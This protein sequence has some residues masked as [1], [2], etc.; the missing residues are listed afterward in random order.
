MAYLAPIHKP[1]SIRHAVK[2]NLLDPDE[3]CLVVA[4]ANKIEIWAF[5]GQGL[6][7]CFSD[8]F[9]GRVSMLAKIRPIGSTTDHL[10]IGTLRFSYFTVA[11][12]SELKKLETVN[13]FE[14]LS[15]SHMRESQSRDGCLVDPTGQYVMLELFEGV[16]NL[17]KVTKPRKGRGDDY[18]DKAEQIRLSE[19]KVRASTFLFTE[20]KQPKIALLYSEGKDGNVRLVTYQIVDD[21]GHYSSFNPKKDRENELDGLDFSCSHLIPVP[22]GDRG[23]KRYMVRNSAVPKALLGGII[24]VS[25]SNMTY[26]DDESNAVIKYNLE[27]PS[28]FVAW[29]KLDG[30]NYLLADEYARLFALTILVDGPEVVGMKIRKLGKTTK[31]SLMVLLSEGLVFIASHEGDSQ[32]VKVDL[33]SEHE[34]IVL[35]QTFPNIGPILDFAVMDIGGLEGEN[36]LNDYSSGQ[37]Q[38]VTGSGANDCG[39]VR[40]VRSGVGLEDEG[41]LEN[42]QGVTGIFSLK[43][44]QESRIMDILMI[45]MPVETRVFEFSSEGSIEEAHYFK[46]FNLEETTLLAMNTINGQELQVTPSSVILAGEASKRL[47]SAEW[48]PPEGQQITA[49]SGN[50]ENLLLALNGTILVSLDIRYELHEVATREISS[51]DQVACIFV[52]DQCLGIGVVGFWRSGSISILDLHNLN[53]IQSEGLQKNN[54]ASIP[55]SVALVQVLPANISGPTLF[56]AMEDGIVLT[57][58]VDPSTFRLSGKKSIALGTQQVQFFILPQKNGLSNIFA[59]SEHPSL[60]YGSEGRIIYSAVTADNVISVCS[61]DNKVYADTIIVA[62]EEEVKISR[63]DTQRRTHIRTLPMGVTVRRIA[64]SPKERVLG[65]GC[66]KRELV[67]NQETVSCSFVIAEDVLFGQV[68]REF[69]LDKSEEVIECVIQSELHTSHTNSLAERFIVGT[70]FLENNESNER[71]RILIF[72]IDQSRS[73]YLITSLNLKCAC[74]RVAILNGHIVAALIKTVVIYSYHETTTNSAYLT[75]ICA[76]R[77]STCPID[78]AI[79]DNIIAVADLQKSLVLLEYQPAKKEGNPDTLVEIARH[80]HSYWATAVSHL[81]DSSYLES[82]QEGNLIILARNMEGVTLED[83]RRLELTGEFHL[84][85]MVNRMQKIQV[86]PTFNAVIIPRAFLA[87]TEGSIYLLSTIAP[88]AQD[89][90]I[91]LQSSIAANIKTLGNI[92]FNSY[93]SF[94]NMDR[95]ASE[96]YRFIDGELI[97]RFLDQ[98]ENLQNEIC[99]GLGPHV[100]DIRGLVEELKRLH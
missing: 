4:K 80:Y 99:K 97:E 69:L 53:L 89:L 47:K 59:T 75:K 58:K 18:L 32:L 30:L 67:R 38:L 65:L 86:K 95:E 57:F 54:D 51:G 35:I 31:A 98:D 85:E 78:L 8:S 73:P 14:N 55:R 63:I 79:N 61:F 56:V 40:S 96:P 76:Y 9:Y 44:H 12:N 94:L 100:E 16:I 66:I 15:D 45:S 29:E 5:S 2:L 52:P 26:L 41:I 19:L 48:R 10:F 84:G 17:I 50:F 83:R 33:N 74:R 60:I 88:S 71:G 7:L 43:S 64:Y 6:E 82:D 36:K 1:S 62:T 90:L 87:T 42:L 46:D 49:V 27:E 25:E 20:T 24:V 92:E 11:W 22:K 37:V 72:G 3:S 23:Q 13:L 39:S 21:K 28:I 93:R 81:E 91:R 70:S 77:C 68:G 34:A